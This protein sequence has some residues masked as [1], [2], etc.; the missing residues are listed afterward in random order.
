MASGSKPSS[1]YKRLPHGPHKLDRNEVI[2]NQRARIHGAMIE[3]VA[4]NGYQKTSVK[5]VIALAGVSRRSFYEQ[6][7]NKQECFTVTFDLIVRHDIQ[8]IRQAYLATDGTLEE[9][10]I[11]VFKEFTKIITIERNRATLVV[12][13]AQT[14]GPVGLLHL[15]QVT[16]ACEQMLTRSFTESPNATALPT[17]IIRAI[18]GGLYGATATFLRDGH[19]TKSLKLAEELL[20]WT[21]LFQTPETE[22]MAKQMAAALSV[23]IREISSTN[24]H[25]LGDASANGASMNGHGLGHAEAPS[26]D[27]R[28][29]LLHAV[30]QLATEGSYDE[31][32]G[33]QIAD[34]ANVSVDAFCGLFHSRDDCYLA[35]LDTIS[36]ELLAIA[37]DPDLVGND[38]AHAV[39]RVLAELMSHLTDHPVH[40]RILTQ[41]AFS[42]STESHERVVELSLSIATLLTEGAPTNAQGKLTTE[43]VAGAIW[44]TIR[45]QVSSG[46]IQLLGALS[47]YLA[48][49]IL[50]PFIGANAAVEIL[51]EEFQ[52]AQTSAHQLVA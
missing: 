35:A 46:R 49:V 1:L 52:P 8:Q 11:A 7:A 44:H 39:R 19:T 27:E 22:R 14:A 24:S 34:Y 13:D 20:G 37:A 23:R 47:D 30:L 18:A 40:A 45:Y 16:D 29:R 10:A 32:S 42:I 17:P 33:P 48:Y 9:R 4:R 31:L 2:R 51:T 36:D 43:A 25:S 28:T 21:L 38:W 50:T 15:R 6:F 5:E 3:A 26:H 12:L 41:E